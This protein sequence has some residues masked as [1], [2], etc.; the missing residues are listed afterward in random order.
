MCQG[1]MGRSFSSNADVRTSLF[2][3]D[4]L[5]KCAL[6]ALHT[7]AEEGRDGTD[8]KSLVWETNGRWAAQRSQWESEGRR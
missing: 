8:F 1:S 4:V 6:L 7:I 2:S 3:A 5:K